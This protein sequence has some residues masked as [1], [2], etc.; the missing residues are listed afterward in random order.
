MNQILG[1]QHPQ[2]QCFNIGVRILTD[3]DLKF[4][5]ATPP[6]WQ[7]TQGNTIIGNL[8]L[9]VEMVTPEARISLGLRGS[10]KPHR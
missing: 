5:I 4:D 7:Y 6:L 1:I 2:C 3:K 8:V 10:E 9:S